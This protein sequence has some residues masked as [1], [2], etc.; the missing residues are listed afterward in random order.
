MSEQE[1]IKVVWP[2][3]KLLH[4]EIV[5]KGPDHPVTKQELEKLVRE[6]LNKCE[7]ADDILSLI[8]LVPDDIQNYRDVVCHLTTLYLKILLILHNG[9]NIA[10][11]VQPHDEV[12][13][14]KTPEDIGPYIVTL[15]LSEKIRL[16]KRGL[17]IFYRLNPMR[18]L[19]TTCCVYDY[20]DT[21]LKL[22]RESLLL[23]I[24]VRDKDN[25]RRFAK[26]LLYYM[27]NPV[28][29]VTVY[30]SAVHEI[31]SNLDKFRTEQARMILTGINED[32]QEMLNDVLSGKNLE[33][34][35][36]WLKM[37]GLDEIITLVD[38]EQEECIGPLCSTIV[39][40]YDIK[41]LPQQL[42][43]NN[44]NQIPNAQLIGTISTGRCVILWG[45]P[46]GE[47]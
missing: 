19:E 25:L 3:I 43:N 8:A 26:S 11:A 44:D 42:L 36:K 7:N 35:K 6:N 16:R 12:Y 34:V 22:L 38:I 1:H 14:V 23:R 28:H 47:N 24:R 31:L 5:E 37:T 9:G 18:A 45:K 33:I 32:I 39:E 41:L 46:E 4:K 10:D 2:L 30:M 13:H 17:D 21:E 40:N 20:A 27:L 15:S 29:I